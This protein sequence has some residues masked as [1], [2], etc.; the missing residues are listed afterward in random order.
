MSSPNNSASD[1]T[2]Q[3]V[4]G[5]HCFDVTQNV[6][7]ARAFDFLAM[8]YP[9]LF[10]D[11]LPP[12]RRGAYT[13]T[14][15]ATGDPVTDVDFEANQFLVGK[16]TAAGYHVL[17]EESTTEDGME[18][19]TGPTKGLI[20][21]LDPL[22]GSRATFGATQPYGMIAGIYRGEHF[23]H[24]GR[25]LI[26]SMVITVGREVQALVSYRGRGAYRFRFVTQPSVW[27][28]PAGNKLCIPRKAEFEQIG[29]TRRDLSTEMSAFFNEKGLSNGYFRCLAADVDFMLTL[30]GGSIFLHPKEKLRCLYE[31]LVVMQL[32]EEA[33]GAAYLLDGH[34]ARPYYAY[35]ACDNL[36]A[37]SA[38]V[39][40][41]KD[42]VRDFLACLRDKKESHN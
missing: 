1:P 31:C 11:I 21:A 12:G 15:N 14:C 29:G 25:Q 5:R 28:A 18:H 42:T 35:A 23:D 19:P 7:L 4:I 17:S 13:G 39:F 33:G 20:I 2:F 36:H 10:V 37:A 38:A 6:P 40:G 3:T 8:L 26:G 22:D 41:S 9:Q 30:S 16:L 34:R 27:N 24:P 32:V